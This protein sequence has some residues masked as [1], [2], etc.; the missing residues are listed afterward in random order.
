M[1]KIT[2]DRAVLEQAV[3]ALDSDSPDIQLR[4]A[5]A[6]RGALAQPKG[7]ARTVKKRLTDDAWKKTR[8]ICS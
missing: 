7:K 8:A 2:I 6:L 4:A 3:E 1:T 5:I